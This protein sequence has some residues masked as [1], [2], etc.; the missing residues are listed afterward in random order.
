[1]CPSRRQITRI[2]RHLTP[3][4]RSRSSIRRS[5]LGFPSLADRVCLFFK[6]SFSLH[7]SNKQPATTQMNP[8]DNPPKKISQFDSEILILIS[9]FLNVKE[10]CRFRKSCSK[11]CERI[12]WA[13]QAA[14]NADGTGRSVD[15]LDGGKVDAAAVGGRALKRHPMGPARLRFSAYK[16][17]VD[18][19]YQRYIF[20]TNLIRYS[21]GGTRLMMI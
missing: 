19:L 20:S 7:Q 6:A 18:W 12:P 13:S 17:S 15:V 14:S 8:S 16:E 10:Y 9:S 21:E 5:N 2:Y 1:M 3:R 11:V 4:S